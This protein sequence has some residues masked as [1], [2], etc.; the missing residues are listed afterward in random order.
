MADLSELLGDLYG[1]PAGPA[2]PTPSP[3]DGP[4][5]PALDDDLAIALSAALSEAPRPGFERPSPPP[6]AGAGRQPPPSG[7]G[8]G[9]TWQRSDDDIL[10]HRAR[11]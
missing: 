5:T 10:P 4:R 7:P 11:R 2:A 1:E 9:R 3:A 8:A 6:D